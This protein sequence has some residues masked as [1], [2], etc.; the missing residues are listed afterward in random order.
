MTGAFPLVGATANAD[1]FLNA[2]QQ[3]S[4]PLGDFIAGAEAALGSP[5][6]LR[7]K[8]NAVGIARGSISSWFGVRGLTLILGL[9]LIAGAVFS[10]PT[11]INV[12]KKAGEAAA[13]AA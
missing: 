5:G 6:D 1:A 11:V 2:A 7:G 3:K 10:H 8:M 13:V 4:N 12:A 9:L